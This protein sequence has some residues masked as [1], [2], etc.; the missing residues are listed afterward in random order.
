MRDAPEGIADRCAPPSGATCVFRVAYRWY[1]LRSKHRLPS[2][3][4]AACVA[5]VVKTFDSWRVSTHRNSGRVPPR[6]VPL[7]ACHRRAT[8]AAES[9]IDPEGITNGS[10]RS[11]RSGA[12]PEC[13][14]TI[15]DDPEGITDGCT[16]PSGATCVFRVVYR[17][18]SL[19]SGHRLPSGIPAGS[20]TSVP[21]T[22]YGRLTSLPLLAAWRC[23]LWGS[24]R[25]R[26]PMPG[27]VCGL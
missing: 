18:Y 4:P 17:W 16:P 20:V 14:V 8:V 25:F 13:S 24:R 15:R 12:P 27:S 26:G 23:G 1:S 7:Q 22:R 9:T 11:S 5:E 19:R 3:I 6:G 10:R 2:G 21:S